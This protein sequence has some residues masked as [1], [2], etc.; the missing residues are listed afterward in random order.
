MEQTGN[1]YHDAT[2]RKKVSAASDTL[3]ETQRD[4]TPTY[5]VIN[6]QCSEPSP[7]T[8]LTQ[9]S[10]ASTTLITPPPVAR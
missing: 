4:E 2:R 10:N 7:A 6:E 3:T 5:M 8:N 1:L 9:L